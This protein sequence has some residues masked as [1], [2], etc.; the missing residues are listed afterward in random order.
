MSASH[1]HAPASV[2]ATTRRSSANAPP[3]AGAAQWTVAIRA[4]CEGRVNG[5]SASLAN[6]IE[7]READ[8]LAAT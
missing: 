6:R 2:A 5:S 7:R 4:R 3:R 1:P 8:A